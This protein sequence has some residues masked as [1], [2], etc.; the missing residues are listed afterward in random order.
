MVLLAGSARNLSHR[1][2]PGRELG[3][4]LQLLVPRAVPVGTEG[5]PRGAQESSTYPHGSAVGAG[6]GT[7]C[8]AGIVPGQPVGLTDLFLITI[9]VLEGAVVPSNR[10][11]QNTRSLF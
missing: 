11:W 3:G 5:M 10:A 9:T 1:L 4:T 7:Q 2:P 6:R 8:F